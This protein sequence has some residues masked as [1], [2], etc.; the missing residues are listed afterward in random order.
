MTTDDERV[1][2]LAGDTGL[3]LDASERAE[4]DALRALL[5]DE[6]TWAEPPDGLEARVIAAVQAAAAAE[7][8][9]TGTTPEAVP[10]PPPTATPAGPGPS[11]GG[12]GGPPTPIT[13]ARSV[14]RRSGGAGRRGWML[15]AGG[16]AAAIVLVVGAAFLAQL[17]GRSDADTLA[18]SLV[19]TDLAPG[20]SAEA[21]MTRT[22]S[23]WRIELDGSGLP[24][25]DGGRF[26]EAWLRNADGVLVSIGTFN[27]PAQV[28][29]WA[30]V[31]P[32]DFRTITV[33]QEEADGDPTS[34]GQRVLTGEVELG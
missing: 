29:L 11:P 14:R 19:P 5:A 9:S 26:Y 4:L 6:A 33:T 15:A 12:P 20:A 30:G 24:R 13:D 16:L 22:D 2:Y 27:E 32:R 34:S 10:L 18:A 3:S 1:G 17:G 28:T 25:L 31:S 7:A 23:G 8:G 21:T